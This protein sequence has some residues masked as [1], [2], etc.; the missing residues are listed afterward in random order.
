MDWGQ[1]MKVSIIVPNHGRDLSELWK[2][3]NQSTVK[4]DEVKVIDVGRERS[5][6]RN[7]G[8]KESTGDILI[9]LDS[10]QSISQELIKEAKHLIDFGYTAL[11]VPEII[12]A[13]SFFGKIRKFEREFYTGTA[14]DVPR[15]VLKK[16]CPLFDETLNGPEDSHWGRQIQGLRA[17]TK[18]PLFHHDDI[19]FFEYCKK[20]AYYSKS[21]K[22]YQ[23]LNPDCKC[24]DLKYRCFQ[25]FVESGK[26]KKLIRHPI[27]SIGIFFIIFVRGIIYYARR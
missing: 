12:I 9:I 14:V 18:N 19:S 6:Q 15:I 11:Y 26:W 20:K 25:I 21:M 16:A 22:R 3:V 27:L 5:Y 7:K 23:E 10:D 17:I 13:D 4:P 8:I 24:L 2:S 1:K